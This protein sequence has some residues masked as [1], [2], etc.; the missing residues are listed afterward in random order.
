MRLGNRARLVGC[1]CH[2]YAAPKP[3]AELLAKLSRLPSTHLDI[4]TGTVEEQW[5]PSGCLVS[6]YEPESFVLKCCS[7]GAG[8]RTSGQS[9]AGEERRPSPAA[10]PA[11]QGSPCPSDGPR[12]HLKDYQAS[13]GRR[14]LRDSEGC[15]Q[16]PEERRGTSANVYTSIEC[17][18]LLRAWRAGKLCTAAR[19]RPADGPA[20]RP[21]AIQRHH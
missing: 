5:S 6:G 2:A 3:A 4:S 11:E 8:K 21:L 7:C 10:C 19:G 14:P 20:A 16:M 15:G 13:L 12:V 9:R 17:R 18:W 1:D